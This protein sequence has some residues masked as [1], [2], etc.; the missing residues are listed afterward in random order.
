MPYLQARDITKR[1]N[2]ATAVDGATLTVEQGETLALLGPSGCGKTTLLRIL[3]GLEVPD[4]GT[5]RVE[6]TTLTDRGVFVPPEERRIGMVF[7]DWA[8]FP[9][10]TVAKNVSFGLGRDEVGR[11]RGTEALEM[12]GL[13]HLANRYPDELSGGQAQRVALARAL[14]PRPRVLLFD[15]PFSNLDAGMRSRVRTDVASLMREVGMTSIFVTH[16]QEEAFVVG[17]RV[18][19][20][21]EGRIVQVGRPSEVY[22]YP[23]SPWVARFLGSANVLN[24][25]ATNGHVSTPVGKVRLAGQVRGPCRVVIRPEHLVVGRGDQ[26]VVSSVEFY[27]HDTSYELA[28][29]GTKLV[30]RVIAAP[31]FVPGDRVSVAYSGPD[32]V[33][34]AAD[35]GHRPE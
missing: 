8:L 15:E 4:H 25:V 34:F 13:S 9:H 35:A 26:G 18:A 21:S 12:V 11:G 17:D 19:V 6:D 31:T 16:D 33:A 10:L 2:G 32:V 29:N 24:G 5:I 14:A 3:A 30:A 20:M 28:V 7:Q 27:G 23:V 1:F 22:Q